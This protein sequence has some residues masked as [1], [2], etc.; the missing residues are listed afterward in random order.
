MTTL[1]NLSRKLEQSGPYDTASLSREEA[2]RFNRIMADYRASVGFKATSAK[3]ITVD[4]DKLGKSDIPSYGLSLAPAGTS[5]MWNTCGWSTVGCRSVCL[6]TAGNGRYDSVTLGRLWKTRLL[7][8]HPSLFIRRLAD[9]IRAR[10]RLDGKINFR[11]NIVSDLRWERIA[12][13]LF[14]LSNVSFYDYTKAPSKARVK[15]D[16]YKL[17]GSITERDTLAR[18]RSKVEEYGSAA[19]VFDTLKGR[20]LP[21]TYASV[22]VVDGD[23]S[24]D[25]TNVTEVGVLIGLRYKFPASG[26]R[27]VDANGF[28]RLV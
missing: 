9:E 15:T 17:V 16:N 19:I 13:S 27:A 28:V 5:G 12:P 24:D 11:P 18:I 1:P 22:P 3:L 25:R 4:N 2:R 10:A 23:L 26:A 20:P 8:D 7:A 6:S 14:T 21:S